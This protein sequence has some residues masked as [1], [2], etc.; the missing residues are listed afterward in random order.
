M[1]QFVVAT[2]IMLLGFLGFFDS[3]RNFTNSVLSPVEFGLRTSAIN[4]KDAF[5]LFTGFNDIRK[6]NLFLRSKLNDLTS[7][8]V[9]LSQYKKENELLKQQLNLVNPQDETNTYLV[10]TK[11]LGN[12]LD[13]TKTTI[14]LDKG[15]NQGI[16]AGDNVIV[17]NSLV[18]KIREVTLN[19][20]LVDLTT[21]SGFSSTV[22]KASAQNSDFPHA[23]AVG[24]LGTAIQVEQILASETVEVG[25]LFITS[26]KDGIY[27]PDYYVGE[28]L[29]VTSNSAQPL[30]VALLKPALSFD[31]LYIVFVVKNK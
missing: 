31:E 14:Y 12:Y 30:K 11:V 4:I 25:D 24:H 17:G 9:L 8:L 20:S 3:L 16:A 22:V 18:G 5:H 21:S 19:R 7:E 1:R 23:L 27:L 28:V 29:E 13:S 26:G 2:L 10:M 6:D 15:S